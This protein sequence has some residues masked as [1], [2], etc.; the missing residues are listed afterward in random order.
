M[1]LFSPSEDLLC[2]DTNCTSHYLV[3]KHFYDHIVSLIQIATEKC[4]S[5]SINGSKFKVIPVWNEYVKESHA[6]SRDALK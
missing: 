1:Q 4:I 5:S 2:R 6:I 3:N